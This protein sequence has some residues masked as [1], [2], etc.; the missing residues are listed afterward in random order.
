MATAV[1]KKRTSVV[2]K[3]SK[4][5]FTTEKQKV[6]PVL[7]GDSL[8]S[9]ISGAQTNVGRS[10]FYNMKEEQR[11]VMADQ[12]SVVFKEARPFYALMC[13]P[14]GVND[15]N[16]Q[17]IA[18]NLV[19][20]TIR[21]YGLKPHE[22]SPTTKW[23]NELILQA[24][25]NM[26]VPRV[27][28]FGVA[29]CDEKVTK[30][31]AIFLI[32]EYLKRNQRSQTLWAIK[33]RTEMMKILRH[34]EI[35]HKEKE[36]KYP[37]LFKIWKYLKDKDTTGCGQLI[38]D[39]EEVKAGNKEK[40]AKL[41]STVAEGFMQKFGM[42]KDEFWKLFTT[43]GGKFTVK[44]KRLKAVSVKE[45]GAST[46]LDIRKLKLFDLLVYL[47]AL[48]NYPKPKQ[49][50]EV[51]LKNKAKEIAGKLNFELG[52]V[53]LIF[54]NSKS[55]QGTKEQLFHPLLRGMAISLVM[56]EVSSEYKEY[57]TNERGDHLFPRTGNQTNYA[58]G[59]LQALKDGCETIV[60]VGDGY[61]NAPFEGAAHQLL[62]TYKKKLDKD[63][64]IMI[65]HFNPVFAAEVKDVRAITELAP[66]IGVREVE[67]MNESMFLAIAKNQPMFAIKKYCNYLASLQN[68]KAKTLMPSPVQEFFA[69]KDILAVT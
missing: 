60:I 62:Y 3:K 8:I 48:E 54:D 29:L 58:N 6:V 67:G 7:T 49:E 33:Y 30:K 19:T 50:L 26:P 41:P 32:N 42:S 18:W 40:L 10:T 12:H 20:N 63:N 31:R 21:E 52:K 14:H 47:R 35:F 39:Y 24:F 59:I 13:L 11:K 4:V 55:M 22:H 56:K 5:V 36:V 15:V 9:F 69:K 68:Q 53:G 25:E 23:E 28:D 44:E 27:L 61:E 34:L 65:L 2:K 66:Q 1:A 16:K 51:L 37:E 45:A 46:E 64:K 38:K 57:Y 43:E 17:M